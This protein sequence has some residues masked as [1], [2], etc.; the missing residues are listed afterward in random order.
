MSMPKSKDA[1]RKIRRWSYEIHVSKDGQT[2]RIPSG[3][4]SIGTSQLARDSAKRMQAEVAGLPQ[5]EGETVTVHPMAHETI[6]R[7][8][9][10]QINGANNENQLLIEIARDLIRTNLIQGGTEAPTEEQITETLQAR[11]L[12]KRQAAFADLQAKAEAKAQELGGEAV[13]YGETGEVLTSAEPE[14]IGPCPAGEPGVNGEPG[15]PALLNGG[16][17]MSAGDP[18]AVAHEAEL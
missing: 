7:E 4:I 3:M 10:D 15:M 11:V 2:R 17:V 13:V 6:S 5:F 14:G 18:D 1:R 12:G 9:L 16:L 8:I